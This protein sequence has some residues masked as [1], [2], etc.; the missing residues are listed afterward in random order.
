MELGNLQDDLKDVTDKVSVLEKSIE[1]LN[2]KGYVTSNDIP[3][4][5]D[6]VTEDEIYGIFG[7]TK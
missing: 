4:I 6:Y 3:G 1:E 7:Y 2:N 5:L